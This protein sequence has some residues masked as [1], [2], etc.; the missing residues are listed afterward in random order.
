M[1]KLPFYYLHC[2]LSYLL[3]YTDHCLFTV[4]RIMIMVHLK[5]HADKFA[6]HSAITT[7]RI[8]LLFSFHCVKV[9]IAT[10]AQ[11]AMKTHASHFR[12]QYRRY[13][14]NGQWA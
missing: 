14:T 13:S 5:L 11:W 7:H 9:L 8:E 6:D 10:Y 12:H 4:T 3:T 1:F 2:S